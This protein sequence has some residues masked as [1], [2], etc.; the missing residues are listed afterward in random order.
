MGFKKD[1]IIWE[2]WAQADPLYSILTDL[3]KKENKWDQEEF[4]KTGRDYS[5]LFFQKCDALKIP[6]NYE[7]KVL[8]FGCG[9]GRLTI[10]LAE[11]FKEA[12]GIDIS[13]T[14]IEK[15]NQYH[16]RIQN[17]KFICKAVSGI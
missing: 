9:V 12:I 1:A 15:A 13:P 5:S 8:D 16:Q 11:K 3:T 10:Y 4:F 2:K 14:M 17:C 7:G 6:I